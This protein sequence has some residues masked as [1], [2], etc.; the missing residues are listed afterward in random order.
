MKCSPHYHLIDLP[1]GRKIKTR[2]DCNLGDDEELGKFSFGKLLGGVTKLAAPIVGGVVGGP[3][4]AAIGAQVGKVGGDALSKI[5]KK[6][7]SQI[8]SSL[9][10]SPDEAT[11]LL[12]QSGTPLVAGLT[13][14]DLQNI[15]NSPALKNQLLSALQ[16]YNAGRATNKEDAKVITSTIS[17]QLN[18]ILSLVKKD[19]LSKQ[20][21]YE[22][23]QKVK[24]A[25]RWKNNNAKQAKILAKLEALEKR[26]EARGIRNKAIGASFGMPSNV[27]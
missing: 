13:H 26:I 14:S 11:S 6:K 7:I 16:E 17:P 4:G 9:G 10:V 19:T 18:N 5:G 8:A 22:H 3:M 23:N 21:T 1:S 24:D 2:K 15:L 25:D 12:Q 27:L 20:V